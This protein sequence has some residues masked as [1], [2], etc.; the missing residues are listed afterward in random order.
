MMSTVFFS[1]SGAFCSLSKR[2]E[3]F[4]LF[5]FLITASISLFIAFVNVLSYGGFVEG[6]KTYW[7]A[8]LIFR[9]QRYSDTDSV[10]ALSFMRL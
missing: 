5:S 9:L 4:D 2:L 1:S 7:M 3:Y 10:F 6:S 8:F